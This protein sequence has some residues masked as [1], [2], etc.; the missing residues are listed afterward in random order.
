MLIY[1]SNALTV[2]ITLCATTDVSQCK[3]V[4]IAL[5][6]TN[7]S[8]CQSLKVAERVREIGALAAE[9]W[10]VKNWRCRVN[11]PKIPL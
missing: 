2:I 1:T 9:G 11:I 10:A 7:L 8:Q 6:H 5:E 3:D 4:D